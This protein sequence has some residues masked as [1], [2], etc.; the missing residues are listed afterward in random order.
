VTTPAVVVLG[1]RGL[2]RD[3]VAT[4]LASRGLD[5]IDLEAVGSHDAPVVVV[6]VDPATEDWRRAEEL[7]AR[8][9]LVA[10]LAPE[11]DE[12]VAFLRRGADAVLDTDSSVEEVLE[13]IETVA[14]GDACLRAGEARHVVDMLRSLPA[15][16][17]DPPRLTRREREI[18]ASIERGDAVKQTARALEI[19]EK[20]VQNLQSRLFRKLGARNRAQAIARAHE[21]GLL[22]AIV[23]E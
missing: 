9:V 16:D 1:R 22:T 10:A 6:L 14:Q 15:V 8:I 2:T 20:T 23:L 21:L 19:S 7:G 5:T 3:V 13:A 17:L 18:L 4:L 11:P 12:L